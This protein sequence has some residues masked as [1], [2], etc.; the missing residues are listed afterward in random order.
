MT[1]TQNIFPNILL[2]SSKAMG[3]PSAPFYWQ[4]CTKR[5]SY[6]AIIKVEPYAVELFY[7][8]ICTKPLSYLAIIKVEPNALEHYSTTESTL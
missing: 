2:K 7:W 8:Q 1:E 3:K 5:L 4:I 6:P